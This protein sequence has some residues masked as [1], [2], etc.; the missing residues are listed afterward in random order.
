MVVYQKAERIVEI[1]SH[2]RGNIIRTD[3][4]C[5][6][7]RTVFT[8]T[9]TANSL[10]GKPKNMVEY[11]TLWRNYETWHTYRGPL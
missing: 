9:G 4:R 2:F 1:L 5:Y 8:P 11:F 10:A 7:I 6:E 3:N